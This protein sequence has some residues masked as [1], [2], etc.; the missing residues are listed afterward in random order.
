MKNASGH[1]C[2]VKMSGSKKKVNENMYD[3]SS[4]KRITKGLFTWRWGTPVR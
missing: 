3:I 1:Q 2:K 4:Q